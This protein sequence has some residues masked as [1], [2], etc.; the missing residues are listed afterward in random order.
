L[1][2]VIHEATTSGSPG[3]ILQV[4]RNGPLEKEQGGMDS[5]RQTIRLFLLV[6]GVSFVVA[7]LVHFGVLVGGYQHRQAAIAESTIGVVLLAG[8]GLTLI[9][10]ARTR[11]IGLAAQGFALLGTLV[12]VFTIA[13]GVGPRTLPD[14][15]YHLAIV[16]VLVS[17]LIVT[18]RAPAEGA[19]QHV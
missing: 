5:M 4:A 12:G 14:V 16:V 15:A 8:L 9:W 18:A 19:R 10:P 2:L 6:E 3:W 11:L 13:I 17:G 1:R 7:A